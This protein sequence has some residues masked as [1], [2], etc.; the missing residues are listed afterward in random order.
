M[1]HITAP[2]AGATAA[3]IALA[4]ILSLAGTAT[5]APKTKLVELRVEGDGATL[6]QGT[7]YATG[8]AR[9]KRGINPDCDRRP[10]TTRFPGASAMTVLG[11]AQAFNPRLAPV[12]T[13]PT[14]FGPQVCQ[15]GDL[16]SFGV[17]PNPNGGF[18][19]YVN[20]EGAT[21]SADVAK[22]ANGD[23]V[24]WHYSVFPSDPPQPTDPPTVNTGCALQLRGVPPRDADGEFT[25]RV[26]AH[27]FACQSTNAGVTIMGADSATP[28]GANGRYDVTVGDGRT[29]L[30]AARGQDVRSNRLEACVGAASECP[31]AHGRRIQGSSGADR[32]PGTAGDDVVQAA[33]GADVVTLRGGSDRVNCGGGKDVVRVR[34]KG[35]VIR[36]CERVRRS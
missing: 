28:T 1:R 5:A 12:R 13:R 29:E 26:T 22:V 16:Q 8:A 36:N 27:G 15:I 21:S 35:D 3:A 32:L 4:A 23:R 9:L 18:L 10:R 33:A 31:S 30:F 19:Y 11:R 20:Y 34:G 14:D 24:L 6:D 7:W 17:F 25:V 2:Q